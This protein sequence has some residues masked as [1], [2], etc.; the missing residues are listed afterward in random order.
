DA[1]RLN[2]A[3]KMILTSDR[4]L[5]LDFLK[6]TY[7]SVSNFESFLEINSLLNDG[8]LKGVIFHKGKLLSEV[9]I[10]KIEDEKEY[11][12][13]YLKSYKQ[14]LEIFIFRLQLKYDIYNFLV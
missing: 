13:M 1:M 14:W 4:K 7:E 2:D 9:V 12:L 5:P 10:S 8:V 3:L 6:N 11:L